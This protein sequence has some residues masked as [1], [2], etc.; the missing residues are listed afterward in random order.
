M[1]NP[2]AFSPSPTS[3]GVATEARPPPNLRDALE[4]LRLVRREPVLLC[5]ISLE[6][7]A[8]LFGGAVALLPALAEERLGTGAVGLGWLRAAV[9]I[10]AALSDAVLAFRPVGRRVGSTMLVAVGVFGLGTVVLGATPSCAIAFCALLVLSGADAVMVF[11]RATLL[12][13]VAPRQART[14]PRRGDGVHRRVQRAGRVRVGG[15]GQ[16]LGPGPAVVLGGAATLGVAVTWSRLF[17]ALR[18]VDRF[19]EPPP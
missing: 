17:P 4:G 16:L 1:P 5:A 2:R 11:V 9:G 14:R 13:L 19:P 3:N 7:V 6:L 8:V 10:G 12:P 15:T 18:A